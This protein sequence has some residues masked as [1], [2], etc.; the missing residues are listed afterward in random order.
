MVPPC[1]HLIGA[2]AGV[3]FRKVKDKC[4][5]LQTGDAWLTSH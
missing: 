4:V 2:E 1:Q 5:L 3:L